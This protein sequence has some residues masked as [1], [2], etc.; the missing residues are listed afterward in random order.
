MG[1]SRCQITIWVTSI[2]K[3]KSYIRL[4]LW[5]IGWTHWAKLHLFDPRCHRCLLDDHV[6]ANHHYWWWMGILAA[7]SF[8]MHGIHALCDEP[9]CD[10]YWI[11]FCNFG[12]LIYPYLSNMQSS[13]YGTAQIQHAI[14]TWGLKCDHNSRCCNVPRKLESKHY[15]IISH[16]TLQMP[17]NLAM[18][19]IKT[20]VSD[21]QRNIVAILK[22]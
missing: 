8:H 16:A 15:I 1:N 10:S 2:G 21:K 4:L 17:C 18:G 11:A 22:L 6:V 9:M 20:L 7:S 13:T 12:N 3:Q 5:K 19:Y 14:G